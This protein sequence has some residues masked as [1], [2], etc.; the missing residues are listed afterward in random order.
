M[1]VNGPEQPHLG[2]S[3]TPMA[4][5]RGSIAGAQ[6]A[7]RCCPTARS[8]LWGRASLP[9][10]PQQGCPSEVCAR[11]CGA[12]PPPG[13]GWPHPPPLRKAK[14]QLGRGQQVSPC[15]SLLRC[16]GTGKQRVGGFTPKQR[17]SSSCTNV[18]ALYCLG[19]FF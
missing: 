13:P 10:R 4:T 14:A 19:F 9:T 8:G 17:R 1:G 2:P 12:Q 6:P 7:L 18:C 11:L 15:Q 3:P 16:G 5:G